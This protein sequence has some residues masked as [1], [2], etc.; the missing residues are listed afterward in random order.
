MSKPSV[1]I[2]QL[3]LK[4]GWSQDELAERIGM[5]R[6]NISNYERDIIKSI[7][8]ATLKRFADIFGVSS[9]YL[10][11]Q[12]DNSD[13]PEVNFYERIELSDVDLY[14]QFT[15]V[16]DGMGITEEE[17]QYIISFLRTVRSMKN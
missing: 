13:K 16:L 8:S 4:Q 11:G 2:K 10:L 14:N 12:S 15:L 17:R 7:P 5:N 1:I 3:R 6:V 9:D